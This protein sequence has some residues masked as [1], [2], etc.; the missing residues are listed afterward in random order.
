MNYFLSRKWLI[1]YLFSLFLVGI[2]SLIPWFK[3]SQTL[4]LAMFFAV[5]PIIGLI[6]LLNRINHSLN[7]ESKI[8]KQRQKS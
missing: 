3:Y 1:I 6:V 5:A 2:Y 4:T 8:I 7:P